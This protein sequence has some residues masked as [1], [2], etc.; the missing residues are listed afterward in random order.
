MS[1]T[2]PAVSMEMELTRILRAPREL[3]WQAWTEVERL[4][5]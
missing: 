5:Q 3:V 1:T 2:V 4:R